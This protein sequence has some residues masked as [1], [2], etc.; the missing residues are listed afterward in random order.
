MENKFISTFIT[1]LTFIGRPGVKNDM[2]LD[3]L[4]IDTAIDDLPLCDRHPVVM[5]LLQ[6]E[7]FIDIKRLGSL[8]QH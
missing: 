2:V 7:L 3:I 4:N 5:H 8:P 1:P 6:V